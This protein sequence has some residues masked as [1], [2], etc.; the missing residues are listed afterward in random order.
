MSF[1][2]DDWSLLIMLVILSSYMCVQNKDNQNSLQQFTSVSA[3]PLVL[4]L[5]LSLPMGLG[6][7][8]SQDLKLKKKKTEKKKSYFYKIKC[9]KKKQ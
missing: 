5:L 8:I 7:L 6:W 4:V 2:N 9:D 1:N 3:H